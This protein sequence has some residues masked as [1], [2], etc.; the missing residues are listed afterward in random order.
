MGAYWA[1]E[2]VAMPTAF[3]LSMMGVPSK[4]FS[5]IC[6]IHLSNTILCATDKPNLYSRDT[7]TNLHQNW[8]RVP[9]RDKTNQRVVIFDTTFEYVMILFC[10]LVSKM[11]WRP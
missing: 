11:G 6:S 1:Q 7:T 9:L 5:F 2:H 3:H 4:K 10:K 8:E